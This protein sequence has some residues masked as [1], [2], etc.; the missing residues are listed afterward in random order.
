MAPG[1]NMGNRDCHRVVQHGILV[2]IFDAM[3]TDEFFLD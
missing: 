3:L 2:D 1:C